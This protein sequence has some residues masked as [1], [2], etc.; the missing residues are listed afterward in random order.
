MENFEKVINFFKIIGFEFALFL[1]G[2]LGSFVSQKAQKL[3]IWERLTTIFA[4][5]F[6]ANYISPM[7]INFFKIEEKNTYGV[8]FIVGYLGVKSIE[9]VIDYIKERVKNKV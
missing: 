1:A 6:I 2:L 8:A 9:M 4:G 5:G 7:F 3:S